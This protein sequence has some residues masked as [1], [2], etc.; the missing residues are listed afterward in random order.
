MTPSRLDSDNGF[1]ISFRPRVF[2]GLGTGSV[3]ERLGLLRPAPSAAVVVLAVH[4]D[5][6]RVS[7]L[8]DKVVHSSSQLDEDAGRPSFPVG[9][10]PAHSANDH[11]PR[12]TAAGVSAGVP[13]S[14]GVAG[15][16]AS[17]QH[18]TAQQ[19]ALLTHTADA[20]HV[21]TLHYIKATDV[22]ALVY[23]VSDGGS[24][25][26]LQF[27]LVHTLSPW[28][29]GLHVAWGSRIVTLP[30]IVGEMETVDAFARHGVALS[31][32][33]HINVRIPSVVVEFGVGI[34]RPLLA[35]GTAWKEAMS[36]W[37]TE[38]SKH[39]QRAA[40]RGHV[41]PSRPHSG[42]G[43]DSTSHD[44]VEV[45]PPPLAATP[46]GDTS[47]ASAAAV[48]STSLSSLS[49][50]ATQQS[51]TVSESTLHFLGRPTTSTSPNARSVTHEESLT[52]T[53]SIGMVKLVLLG[54]GSGC[55]GGIVRHSAKAPPPAPAGDA[56]M[57][58]PEK[59]A[60]SIASDVP[61]LALVTLRALG[62]DLRRSLDGV[63]G[64][65]E[66]SQVALMESSLA[67]ALTDSEVGSPRGLLR[68]KPVATLGVAWVL[69]GPQLDADASAGA[70]A[71]AD[72]D[73]TAGCAN[74]GGKADASVRS[75]HCE[76]LCV[77]IATDS[78]GMVTV[79][80]VVG[81]GTVTL[82]LPFLYAVSA[83][84]EQAQEVIAAE[85]NRSRYRNER[86]TAGPQRTRGDGGTA[87]AG[88]GGSGA[89]GDAPA[90]SDQPAKDSSSS[91][92]GGSVLPV[93]S[94]APHLSS[95]SHSTAQQ[96][97]GPDVASAAGMGVFPAMQTPVAHAVVPRVPPVG[98]W[99][100]L[101]ASLME[102]SLH[103]AGGLWFACPVS[104]PQ[105][106]ASRAGSTPNGNT[107][108]SDGF[109]DVFAAVSTMDVCVDANGDELSRCD[110]DGSFTTCVREVRLVLGICNISVE[111]GTH[112][113]LHVAIG[114]TKAALL[115]CCAVQVS[116]AEA[117]AA[118]VTPGGETVSL[119]GNARTTSSAT[120][121]LTATDSNTVLS[122]SYLDSYTAAAVSSVTV[123]LMRG[124]P[125]D[126]C[127]ASISADG[128]VIVIVA[129]E[130]D[131]VSIE[132]FWAKHPRG[133]ATVTV[134]HLG[135]ASMVRLGATTAVL[136]CA[137]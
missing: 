48:P 71:G 21:H 49:A 15:G 103:S 76:A 59:A 99:N 23:Q 60:L 77:S 68:Y 61:V 104:T 39:K 4:C 51:V 58:S 40:D 38:E 37:A 113:L 115:L 24:S 17:V 42:V 135:A 132:S 105:V 55:E 85:M 92:T 9:H 52:L 128:S 53:G 91:A 80:T 27:P 30:K 73:V 116:E 78:A 107:V 114:S 130:V 12:G 126:A 34:L 137:C 81:D 36:V 97:I 111:D 93:P 133:V 20:T 101:R 70:G 127:V 35:F 43:I 33:G 100:Q 112:K 65:F 5:R 8:R 54:P 82:R 106:G 134:K 11:G 125:S 6:L 102:S 121:P 28:S 131:D 45:D 75:S 1:I 22:R 74:V 109:R 19:A 95:G 129:H 56:A 108:A 123:T 94:S 14:R 136:L 10:D 86:R 44:G 96:P 79:H 46:D 117:A 57:A 120:P 62:A 3:S 41:V 64:T 29:N 124:A 118:T 67:C 72:A 7:V 25:G 66:L 122:R 69:E 47:P 63:H 16:A 13:V 2:G 110:S 18:P 87:E 98:L 50:G 90:A 31:H 84:V 119:D 32:S 26:N 89:A 83:V 88:S